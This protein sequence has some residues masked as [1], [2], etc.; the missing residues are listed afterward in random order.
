MNA[1][2]EATEVLQTL[3]EQHTGPM[4]MKEWVLLVQSTNKG[5]HL[6]YASIAVAIISSS[7]SDEPMFA[8]VRRGMY[9]TIRW[10]SQ[11]LSKRSMVEPVIPSV[12]RN[13][14]MAVAPCGF[15]TKIC[16][17]G[18]QCYLSTVCHAVVE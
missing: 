16:H 15:E 1:H 14:V 11:H 12:R 18:H 17:H 3:T 10:A 4:R 5:K 6:Q 7:L 8:K 13:L 2:R 9:A